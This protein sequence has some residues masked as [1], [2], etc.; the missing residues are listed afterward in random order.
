MIKNLIN[1][2][3]LF[4]CN[5]VHDQ[6]HALNLTKILKEISQLRFSRRLSIK[7]FLNLTFLLTFNL[8]LFHISNNSATDWL[9]KRRFKFRN[10]SGRALVPQLRVH[11][12]RG[13]VCF[14]KG[15]LE[16]G[17]WSFKGETDRSFQ[18]SQR[19]TSLSLT[20]PRATF[21]FRDY[22]T[23]ECGENFSWDQRFRLSGS[24]ERKRKRKSDSHTRTSKSFESFD[25]FGL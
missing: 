20:W 10:S 14:V 16:V 22:I 8:K 4:L 12:T 3:L 6:F 13:C 7:T 25:T 9:I 18:L 15:A 21:L 1:L 5:T 24:G 2:L 23:V 11:P 17:R 19:R